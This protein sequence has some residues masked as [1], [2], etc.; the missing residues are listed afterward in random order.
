MFSNLS[1]YLVEILMSCLSESE[2]EFRQKRSTKLLINFKGLTDN[3][4]HYELI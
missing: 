2:V 3:E 1:E 4:S